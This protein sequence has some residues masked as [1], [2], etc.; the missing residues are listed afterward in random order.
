MSSS[1]RRFVL[2]AL[3]GLAACGFEPAFGPD[4]LA[5]SISNRTAFE[6][7]TNRDGFDFVAQL[8][9]RLGRADDSAFR[10]D[11]DITVTAS[12]RAISAAQETLRVEFTGVAT[13]RLV[14]LSDGA[15]MDQGEVRGFT[16]YARTSVSAATR[17]NEV[18]ARR[19][20]MVILAD[21][22]VTRI[23]GAV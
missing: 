21:N 3:A 1:N 13:Y 10:L 18:D 7:P 5:A 2:L 19:R 4:K 11:W 20:L 12:N 15:I 9:R 16:G 22:V 6:A 14:Q 17:S 8:E 23:L